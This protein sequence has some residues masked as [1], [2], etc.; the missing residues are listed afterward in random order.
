MRTSRRFFPLASASFL[1]A[2]LLAAPLSGSAEPLLLQWGTI[3]TASNAAQAEST[4]LKAK[5]AKKAAR[6]R[7]R[8]RAT[9]SRAAYVVQFP[10]PVTAEWRSWLESATQ[11]RGY[12]P[13]FAYLVWATAAEMETIAANTN[14][15]WSGEWKKDY[16]TVRAGATPA[17]RATAAATESRWMQIGSLLTGPDGA[18]D[19]RARLEALPADVRSAFPR[20]N[21]CS[22]VACLTDAQIDT[23]ASWPDVEWIEP[24]P[25]PR[26]ANDQAARDNMMNVSN[27]WAALSSGGLGLTGA[28]QIVAVADTGLDTGNTNDIH[29]DFAGR[30][31]A[32]YGWTNRAY[33]PSASWMDDHCHGTHVCGS[34]LGSGAKSSGQ[35]KGMAHEARLVIQGM[36][37]NLRGLPVDTRDMLGQAY[38]A[39]ARI[40]SDSWGY[41]TNFPGQYD[42][43]SVYVDI[44]SWEN[45]N[46]LA[47]IAA[48]NEGVDADAGGVIDPGSVAC[49]G[50]S[51][52]CL[53]VGAA[54]NYRSYGGR[55]AAEWG[56]KWPEKFPADPVKSGTVSSTNV[57]QGLAAFSGRGPT[58]DGRFKPDIVAP[59]TDIISV[60]SRAASAKG[61]GVVDSNTNYL[62]MGGT[63]M[64]TPLAS[65]ALAL[66][67]QWLV[68]YR[69]IDEPSAALMKA[70]LVNGARDMTPGQY[71]TGPT[72]EITGRPDYSQGFGHI[73]LCN[74]LAPGNGRF[75]VFATNAITNSYGDFVTNLVVGAAN[76]GT[77]RITLAWQD[78]PGAPAAAKTL[79]NDLD[80]IVTAPSGTRY[81]PNN[82]GTDDHVNNIESVEFAAAE[83]GTWTVRVYG[84]DIAE[85]EPNGGQPFALVM[86]G[87]VTGDPAPA[88]PA[89]AVSSFSDRAVPGEEYLF[90]FEPLLA[91]SGWPEPDFDIN[92]P[93]GVT[94]ETADAMFSFTPQ[95]SGTFD[96]VCT[97]SNTHGS[98]TCTLTVTA[99]PIP[100]A[101]P[102]WIP[103]PSPFIAVQEDFDLTLTD[104]VSGNPAPAISLTVGGD[105][106]EFDPTE[107]NYFYFNSPTVGTYT[108]TFLASNTLGTATA[109]L[110]VTVVPDLAPFEQWL[111]ARNL[112][113]DT[114][115]STLALNERTYYQNYI[116]D[117][118]PTSTN[119][120]RIVFPDTSFAPT[121]FTIPSA[122][123]NRYY[124]LYYST[125]LPAGFVTTNLGTGSPDMSVPFPSPSNWYGNIRVLLSAPSSP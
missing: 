42:Y 38:A 16:K 105:I 41:G 87:P 3:D 19:L 49:P 95:S 28:G 24:K 15:F 12:L 11:V 103:L 93:P 45:Q 8:R 18:A 48:G 34:I 85:T 81:Y 106:A 125:N 86:S 96:F 14:V 52:N 102:A 114:P 57:P 29:A 44:Y 88:A 84:Y 22:A 56:A 63:S 124:Q 51:K 36:G 75:L 107:D 70:L 53:C 116:A 37:A 113:P 59:G 21:G 119:D 4:A 112:D 9:P 117:I 58:T 10:G 1:A 31:V 118:D 61:W 46:F 69:G 100:T 43:D 122:S 92:A 33:S 79:V 5:V 99:E 123:P 72:Q 54:A 111:A 90:D 91:T 39:G 23:V 26:L 71:G 2:A 40:H 83:T 17:T 104:F 76:A 101:A 73:D 27:A 25:E 109:D 80:L 65:G 78:Y 89:F 98:S 13:E 47:V 35:Y 50:T 32:A 121:N 7:R 55:A 108:F 67:R 82:L 30:V 62:Y 115:P 20:L 120:L 66:V 94:C 68:D 97:A 77:Y 60:R 64:A 6:D 74:S 110:A